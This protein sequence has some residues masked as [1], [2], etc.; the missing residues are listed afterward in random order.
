MSFVKDGERIDDLM[1][2][3]LRIIQNPSAFCFGTDAV[4]LSSF[5]AVRKG[6]RVVD[7][8]TGTGIIPILLS[9]REKAGSI[10]GIEIQKDMADMAGRSVA[11]NGLQGVVG[12]V[13]GDI[14]EA[15][16]LLC[17]VYDVVTVNPPYQKAAGS[18][19]SADA[20][21]AVSRHELLCSLE[22]IV[23]NAAKVLK[24]GGRFY[25]VYRTARFVELLE[26]MTAHGLEPKKIRLVHPS[27]GKEPKTVLVEGKKG[28]GRGVVFQKPLFVHGED[29][30]YTE[31][32][33]KIYHL[34]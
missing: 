2:K 7:F 23:E 19:T 27:Y 11:L 32:V 1:Y 9:A 20:G 28:A 4:L 26:A 10:T 29:G 5:A 13:E 18:R 21:K 6:E 34:V 17:G 24:Y 14:R 30:E 3:G 22:D 16:R 12:I 15:P 8:C 31:E 33:K 25:I